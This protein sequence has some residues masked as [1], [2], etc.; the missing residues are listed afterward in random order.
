M[1]EEALAAGGLSVDALTLT[2]L[3]P[4]PALQ[5]E[6]DGSPILARY[7]LLAQNRYGQAVTSGG[8]VWSTWP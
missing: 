4:L 7:R 1:D 3:G 6:P 8:P 5:M 2:T